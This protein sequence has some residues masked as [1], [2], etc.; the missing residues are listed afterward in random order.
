MSQ[1]EL[2]PSVLPDHKLPTNLTA[3]NFGTHRWFNFIAGFSPELVSN[4]INEARLGNGDSLIDPFAGAG[5][6]LV[7]ANRL[8]LDAVGFEPQP[9]FLE[10][11]R[12]K[13]QTRFLGAVDQVEELLV[14]AKPIQQLE[15]LWSSESSRIFLSKLVDSENLLLLGGM[16]L[17][18][19]KCSG[20]TLPI[21]KLVVSRLLESAAGSQT[22]GIYKAPT[23]TKKSRNVQMM[24]NQLFSEIREDISMAPQDMGHSIIY[25]YSSENMNTVESNSQS[26][27]VTSP[28]YL[29]NFDFAEMSRMEFYFWGVANNW[30]EITELVRSKLIINTTT[31]SA[32][33]RKDYEK[34]NAL[35]PTEFIEKLN[36]LIEQLAVQRKVKLGKKEYD[37]LVIPYFAQMNS[38]IKE[39]QRVL[40]PDANLH[41]I[42][43]DAALYG[44][45]IKTEELLSTLMK[46]AGFKVINIKRLRDRGGRW[47]LDKREGPGVPLGEFHIRAM[48]K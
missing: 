27:C 5:T 1:L 24:M 28:P 13:T 26:I 9:F 18:E 31:V 12:A 22:D 8:G 42:V 7:E 14:S 46:N 36:P 47:I 43:A 38:V 34:W 3:R 40:K 33:L 44:V 21:F 4:E 39:L 23:S 6:A 25:P 17:Q 29:N 10:M 35:L 20:D 11:A 37:S 2:I 41:L 16:R 15:D 19:S 45:H 48:K 32:S 30:K